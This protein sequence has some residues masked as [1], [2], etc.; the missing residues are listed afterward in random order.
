LEEGIQKILKE[1]GIE[2]KGVRA[3]AV[4]QEMERSVNL[5]HLPVEEF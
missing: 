5:L 1:R 4:E 2:S 3:I